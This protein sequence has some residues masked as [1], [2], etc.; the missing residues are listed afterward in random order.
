MASL[1]GPNGT[2]KRTEQGPL[3]SYLVSGPGILPKLLLAQALPTGASPV[4]TYLS[5]FSSQTLQ[6]FPPWETLP[7]SRGYCP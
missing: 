7:S 1:S 2:H 5:G 4:P 6:A 3:T